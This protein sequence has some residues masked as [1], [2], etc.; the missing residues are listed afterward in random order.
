VPITI[1]D[2]SDIKPERFDIDGRTGTATP[3]DS[4]RQMIEAI[5]DQ[6]PKAI[7]VDIDFSLDENGQYIH[8]RDP[9]FFQFCIDLHR[10]TGIPI[11]LGIKRTIGKSP[12]EWLGGAQYA[13]LAA[14][15]VAP[16]DNKRMV[17]MI[18]V[19][20]AQGSSSINA[21]SVALADSYGRD[22][23]NSAS[24]FGQIHRRLID[25]FS[26]YHLLEKFTRR[27]LTPELLVED[28]LVDFSPLRNIYV[29]R[30]TN[31]VVI[32]DQ[33]Q[34][35]H[36][37][38]KIVLLGDAT[39]GEGPDVFTVPG[40]DQLYRG[41]FLHACA[42]Y[43]LITAPLYEVTRRGRF[44]IDVLFALLILVAITCIRLQ[45]VSDIH[46]EVATRRLRVGFTVLV[47]IVALGIGLFF[48]HLTRIMWADFILAAF[49]LTFH[50][51][52]EGIL[53][54]GWKFTRRRA[55]VTFRYLV[56]KK[57]QRR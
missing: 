3:R 43:T 55:F 26:Q 10:Q 16:K 52:I 18:R 53:E 12:A 47:L 4:L 36:F 45:F 49:A 40:S 54:S 29:L 35:Q 13:E 7:G 34:R 6:N 48:V 2:I 42:A 56:L 1:L 38:G 31:P 19:D 14:N 32:R 30:T 17:N 9:T 50:G 39:L 41:V 11:F 8:P 25:L 23:N 15:I 57:Q 20:Q 37:D 51:P 21:M 33:S 24:F 5:A 27:Q 28:F 46:V 44:L 22:T